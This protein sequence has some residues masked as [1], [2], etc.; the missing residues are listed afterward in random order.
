M[1]FDVMCF[2]YESI[3]AMKTM[4]DL[5]MQRIADHKQAQEAEFAKSQGELVTTADGAR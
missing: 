1:L 3:P 4:E 5:R 2:L